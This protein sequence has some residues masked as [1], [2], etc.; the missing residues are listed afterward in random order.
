MFFKNLSGREVFYCLWVLYFESILI[1]TGSSAHNFERCFQRR[2]KQY[3][4]HEAEIDERL[5]QTARN[6]PYNLVYMS[7]VS[8]QLGQCGNQVGQELFDTIWTDNVQDGQRKTGYCTS[9]W[10]RFFRR[11]ALG[12]RTTLPF[13]YDVIK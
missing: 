7:V 10:D 2:R 9:S 1:L 12:G 5:A 8:V 6:K 4:T 13:Y 11:T 3:G